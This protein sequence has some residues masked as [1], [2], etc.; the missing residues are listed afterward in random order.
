M[1]EFLNK[2]SYKEHFLS[3]SIVGSVTA[4]NFLKDLGDPERYTT[5]N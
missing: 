5:A 3:I 2:T 1:S 4:S